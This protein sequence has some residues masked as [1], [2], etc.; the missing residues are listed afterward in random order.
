ML[1]SPYENSLHGLRRSRTRC[2]QS[3]SKFR[4]SPNTGAKPRVEGSPPG[5]AVDNRALEVMPAGRELAL[6]VGDE[7]AE[8]RIV[9]TRVHLGN[10][11]NSHRRVNRYAFEAIS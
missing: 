2:G 5:A 11:E 9:P 7:D 10:E 1:R 4:S 8:V 3:H 6:E